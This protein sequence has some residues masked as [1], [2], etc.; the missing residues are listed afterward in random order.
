MR[1]LVSAVPP[2][3]HVVPLLDIAA[4][5]Q[6]AG[7]E[8]RFATGAQSHQL[9]ADAGLQPVSAGMSSAEMYAERRRRWPE[10][11]TQPP[12]VWATRMWAQVMA[13]STLADLRVEIAEWRPDVIVHDEGE[14][15]G[16]VAAAQ[17]GIP[18]VTHAWGSPLRPA[19]ELDELQDW[20]TGMWESCGLDTPPAAG[21]YAHA[22]I[23]PCPP[24]LQPE[25]I[26]ATV[27]WPIR[28]RPLDGRGT[29]VRADAYVGFGT[30][31]SFAEAPAELEAAVRACASRGMRVVVTAPTA[32]LRHRLVDIDA[33]LV[34]AHEFVLLPDLLRTCRVVISHAGAGTV[35]ASLAG[36][37]PVVVV[38]RGSP[39][40]LRMADACHRA[41]VGRRCDATG[42]ASALADVLG[43]PSF[44]E[45]ATAAARQITAMPDAE[46]IVP[47]IERLTNG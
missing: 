27:V 4:A 37:V 11:D 33:N 9:V 30:V 36:G 35:L 18:W 17:A 2:T 21:L 40:Q 16:P 41:G 42:I 29:Q 28:P 32:E 39:S 45:A 34:E 23:N 10:T 43:N 13:P 1:V 46:N 20:A 7:H 15:A 47:K 31:P 14:Y 19:T 12:S 26:G 3:G 44:A 25:P 5:M 8:V 22:L 24:V 6:R 38:P